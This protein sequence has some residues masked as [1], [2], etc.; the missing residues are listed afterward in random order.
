MTDLG[1][2]ATESYMAKLD[3]R[4]HDGQKRQQRCRRSSII[5]GHHQSRHAATQGYVRDGNADTGRS[6]KAFGDYEQKNEPAW[7]GR[8]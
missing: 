2:R 3:R 4:H 1:G 6:Q 8:G 5:S 7:K